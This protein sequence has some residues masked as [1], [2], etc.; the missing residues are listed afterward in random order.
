MCDASFSEPLMNGVEKLKYIDESTDDETSGSAPGR[1]H[2]L[3]SHD[4]KLSNL[5]EEPSPA[6]PPVSPTI[7]PTNPSA[8]ETS[9]SLANGAIGE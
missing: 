8:T 4:Q 5:E 9:D 1:P 3:Q 7:S 2:P 6:S